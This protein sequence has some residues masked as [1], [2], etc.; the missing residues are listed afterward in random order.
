MAYRAEIKADEMRAKAQD[1]QSPANQHDTS[2][3]YC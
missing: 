3:R 1:R 2:N